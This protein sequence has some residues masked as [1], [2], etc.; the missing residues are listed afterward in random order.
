MS[1]E[2]TAFLSRLQEQ[3]LGAQ[4]DGE[5][6]I[7]AYQRFIAACDLPYFV[8]GV[9]TTKPDSPPELSAMRSNMTPAWL[10]EY[11]ACN[12]DAHDYVLLE[13]HK[14]QE[15]EVMMGLKW[16]RSTADRPDVS[17][18]T[19]QVLR[20]AADAG[21]VSAI[22]FWGRTE[23]F[24]DCP[25]GRVFGLSIGAPEKT[26]EH[27]ET[28]F[29]DRQ[30]ELLI[31][32]F[33]MLPVLRPMAERARGGFRGHLTPREREVLL[34]FSQGLRPERIAEK[35]GLARVT[36]DLHAANARRK[37]SAQT[38]AEAVAKAIVYGVI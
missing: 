32:A 25:G 6:A 19:R 27:V 24:S 34:R 4:P 13:A 37:L 33:A 31:A 2:L 26:E 5:A 30:N 35:L 10:E 16:S 38:V 17:P 18:E 36:V 7:A 9:M 14:R 23:Q 1:P 3:L 11:E 12:Y 22:S 28:L 29:R 8:L 20:G 15:P 21:L